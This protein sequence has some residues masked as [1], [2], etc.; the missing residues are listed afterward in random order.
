MLDHPNR[1]SDGGISELNL[2]PLADHISLY[3]KEDEMSLESG[4][5]DF[6]KENL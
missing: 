2:Q 5:G 6:F 1:T 4:S 3:F